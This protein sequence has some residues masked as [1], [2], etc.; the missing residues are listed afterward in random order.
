[1]LI[2]EYFT[3]RGTGK[4]SISLNKGA[5]WALYFALKIILIAA[6]CFKYSS[7]GKD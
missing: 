7:V 4:T 1:M 6:F 2:K 5:V 3:S